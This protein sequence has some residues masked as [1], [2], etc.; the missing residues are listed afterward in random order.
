MDRVEAIVRQRS[1][2]IGR[3][4]GD[5]APPKTV[6]REFLEAALPRGV[7]PGEKGPAVAH[8]IGDGPADRSDG[9]IAKGAQARP[10]QHRGNGHA[11]DGFF[12]RE[13]PVVR[14][15]GT[16][17]PLV[18]GVV[19]EETPLDHSVGRIRNKEDEGRHE[20]QCRSV[21]VHELPEAGAIRSVCG[22]IAASIENT[23]FIDVCR[24]VSSRHGI[25]TVFVFLLFFSFGSAVVSI[26]VAKPVKRKEM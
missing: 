4:I 16:A 23:S 11:L 5:L 24:H 18:V 3:G 21:P 14:G 22:R 25:V 15:P 20:H 17:E 10:G 1:D 13:D 7:F 2:E 12:Q 9:G 6:P 19:R 8:R 26:G